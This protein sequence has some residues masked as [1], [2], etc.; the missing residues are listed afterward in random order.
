[1]FG[2]NKL[3]FCLAE[4]RMFSK[5]SGKFIQFTRYAMPLMAAMSMYLNH[6]VIFLLIEQTAPIFRKN[7]ELSLG[8]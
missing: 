2:T 1:M 6:Q 3:N 8:I 4:P 5:M 7:G